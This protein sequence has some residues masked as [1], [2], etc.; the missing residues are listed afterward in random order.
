[1]LGWRYVS[2]DADGEALT[3]PA[4]FQDIRVL[5]GGE[6]YS[7]FVLRLVASSTLRSTVVNTAGLI[8]GLVRGSHG[9][10]V[11]ITEWVQ[12]E[13]WGF[14]DGGGGGMA[15]SWPHLYPIMEC[16]PGM[17]VRGGWTQTMDLFF[18]GGVEI[19]D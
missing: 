8:T 16:S 10:V 18:V 3:I 11:V 19:R 2:F 7:F 6:A 1:M 5:A 12:V 9:G 15:E 4:S 13:I 17:R 14:H